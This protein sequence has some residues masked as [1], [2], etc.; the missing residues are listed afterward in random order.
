MVKRV[1][2]S[3]ITLAVL[4]GVLVACSGTTQ[5]VAP[6][7][8]PEPE[9]IVEETPEEEVAEPLSTADQF[10]LVKGGVVRLEADTCY[11]GSVGTGFLID[12]NHVVTVAHVVD[13]AQEIIAYVDNE[14]AIAEVVAIDL[15]RDLALL[16]TDIP[17]GSYYFSL[18]DFEYRT[19][20]QISVIG[21]PLG[22][23]LS[24]TVGT[25]SN[26]EV[27]FDFLPLLTFMQIDAPANP[28]N[29]GGPVLNADGEVIGIVDWQISDTQG[30]NFAINVD[31]VDRIFNSWV[32]N[33][34]ISFPECGSQ[35][36]TEI[37]GPSTETEQTTTPAPTP[38][39]PPA[40]NQPPPPQ[41]T[42]TPTPQPTPTPTPVPEPQGPTNV[43]ASGSANGISVSWTPPQYIPRIGN[44]KPYSRGGI[45]SVLYFLGEGVDRPGGVV[46]CSNL[47]VPNYDFTSSLVQEEPWNSESH[48]DSWNTQSFGIPT[49]DIFGGPIP[50]TSI[51]NGQLTVKVKV[52]YY[53]EVDGGTWGWCA[54]SNSFTVPAS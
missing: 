33:T 23:Y 52:E 41:P 27:S 31:S 20:D 12:E 22:L 48:H 30:L 43:T 42:P 6:T 28:G 5:V 35:P 34:P 10:E 37:A 11:G 19:G 53:Y 17:V 29:S 47:Q 51:Q 4:M 8:E 7:P 36:V 39:T 21:F 24:L 32:D 18:G 16:R 46:A 38:T 13:E 15:D 54:V 14:V 1:L 25:I 2:T 26:A 3:I 45:V 44:Q 50:E 9:P 40:N 49:S